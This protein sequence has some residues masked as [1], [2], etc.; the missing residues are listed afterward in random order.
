M[1]INFKTK[2]RA[3]KE[4]TLLCCWYQ[5][6]VQKNLI[7]NKK[8]SMYGAKLKNQ[9]I[10]SIFYTFYWLKFVNFFV[11]FITTYIIESYILGTL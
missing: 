4:N 7:G 5:K 6:M 11:T 8:W 10:E 9:N 3:Y 2:H 1:Q